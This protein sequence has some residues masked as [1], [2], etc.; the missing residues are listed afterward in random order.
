MNLDHRDHR[1]I[2]LVLASS[3][4]NFYL[5]LF[6]VDA[7][8]SLIAGL[9]SLA[10][11]TSLSAVAGIVS[12]LLV[13]ATLAMLI[14]IIFIPHLPKLVFLPL[15]LFVLWAAFGAP[16]FDFSAPSTV[17]AVAVLEAVLVASVLLVNK[18]RTGAW[19]MR[20]RLLPH[21]THLVLRTISSFVVLGLVLPSVALGLLLVAAG[22]MVERQTDGY[23]QFTWS[24]IDVRETV[25]QREGK[26]VRLVGM[27]HVGQSS[28]YDKLYASFPASA[29]V[30]AEGVTDREG[31]LAGSFSYKGLADVLGLKVQP[32]LGASAG[33]ID[34]PKARP[35]QS[36]G[37][38]P[39]TES[40]EPISIPATADRPR[41]IYADADVSD[42]SPTT[43]RFL[44]MVGEV[45]SSHSVNELLSR[46]N[47]VGDAFSE[48]DIENVFEDILYKRNKR[49]LA[50]FDKEIDEYDTIIIPWGA[51][52]MPGLEAALL[53]R[54][55]R[56]QSQKM[57]AV[58]RYETIIDRLWSV[59]QHAQSKTSFWYR[60]RKWI[61]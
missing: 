22:S 6:A 33:N 1:S 39:N 18:M 29:L 51:Q 37:S 14:V 46:L 58:A 35:S 27:I 44:G 60:Q 23:L 41:I 2:F 10:E 3:F 40:R 61:G 20:A 19:F 13:L 4:A 48:K 16:P 42:F 43:V 53:Q 12:E 52:H 32:Q 50:E 5:A 59:F 17:A 25:L 24:G 7:G 30:L 56:I 36:E 26:T 11:S 15:I 9:L 55:F 28:F 34:I 38:A 31:K 21:K 8:L 57:L 49:V 47:A 54:G 45:Y